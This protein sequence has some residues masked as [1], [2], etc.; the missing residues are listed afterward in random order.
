MPAK[1]RGSI[2]QKNGKWTCR[3][4]DLDGKR[5]ER[6]GFATKSEAG[7]ALDAALREVQ[8]GG[9]GLPSTTTLQQLVDSFLAQHTGQENTKRSLRHRLR[10]A[11]DAWGDTPVRRI[12]SQAVGLWRAKL[13]QGSAWQIHKA[14]RQVLQYGVDMRPA[15]LHENVAKAMKNPEPKR[16]EV[17]YLTMDEVAA[18]TAELADPV[19]RAMVT[20]AAWTGLR[21]SEWL[22]LERQDV[23]RHGKVL[24]VRRFLREGE[25]AQDGKTADSVRTVPLPDAVLTALDA[26]PARIDTPLLFPGKRGGTIHYNRWCRNHWKPALEAAQLT[27]RG[28]YALRHSYATWSIAAGVGLFELARHM[29]TSVEQIDA[30]YGHKTTDAVERAR[31]ALNALAVGG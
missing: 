3:W 13:P 19:H 30:T 12:S 6:G 10:Y 1:Q 21:P 7:E 16:T 26:L 23:D 31:V 5:H 4:Y 14:L 2:R 29:G 17:Q 9:T 8:G 20:L 28:P 27:H 25:I 15:L 18:V 22:A 24:H 11:T